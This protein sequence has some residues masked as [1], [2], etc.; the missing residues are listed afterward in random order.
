VT[1][2]QLEYALACAQVLE[3][4]LPEISQRHLDERRGRRA[5]EHLPSMPRRSDSSGAMHVGSGIPLGSEERSACVQADS[6]LYRAFVEP[7]GDRRGGSERIRR[8]GEREE[9][10]VTLRI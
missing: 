1:V 4:V 10:C 8:L 7:L 5:H 9:E 2:S 3:P 6:Y